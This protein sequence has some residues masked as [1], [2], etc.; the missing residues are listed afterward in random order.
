MSS[1]LKAAS[2]TIQNVLLQSFLSDPALASYISVGAVVS[3]G[4]PDD[5]ESKGQFG[6]SIWLYRLIRDEQTLN[7]PVWRPA[8]NRIRHKLLP[9]RL[10]YLMTAITANTPGA[11]TPE[12]EQLL[13]GRVL[14]TFNDKPLLS[15]A[16]LL[17]AFRGTDIALG[18]RLEALELENIAR[19][20]DSL[21]RSYQ[22]C[23]SYEVGIVPI[24]SAREDI[25]EAPV[26]V[27]L[28]EIGIGELVGGGP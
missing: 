3:L 4:T 26:A 19:I 5:M 11:G 1:A 10:H 22:L 25:S 18:V 20:W 6:L 17:D 28:P 16:D 7:Q 24:E 14:Q 21:E 9:V 12:T 13:L 23:L 8:P 15:G 2:L 27:A